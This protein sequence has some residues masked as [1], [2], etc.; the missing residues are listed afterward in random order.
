M[1]YINNIKRQINE[2]VKSTKKIEVDNITEEEEIEE[3]STTAGVP[4]YQTP[5]AFGKGPDDDTIEAMGYKKATV[6]KKHTANESAFM[7]MSKELHINEASYAEYKSD[8]SM[9]SKAKLNTAIKDINSN[10]Y[11]VERFLKQNRKLREEENIGTD[12]YW[13]STAIK[14][15]K[16]NER[17]SRLQKELKQFGLKEIMVKIAQEQQSKNI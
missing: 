7:K 15:V 17:L 12:N 10:L 4:G 6:K 1:H 8:T 14:L 2:S 11:Q 5:Y 16:M 9:S 3:A 13:K